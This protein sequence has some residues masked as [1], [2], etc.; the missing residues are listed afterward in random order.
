MVWHGRGTTWAQ[1]GICE[2]ALNL[3]FQQT[4]V[5]FESLSKLFLAVQ[6]NETYN[7]CNIFPRYDTVLPCACNNQTTF[8]TAEK[9]FIFNFWGGLCN[10][11]VLYY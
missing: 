5:D 4:H 8:L 6:I 3:L 1:H 9:C 11:F 7:S 10:I 2:L